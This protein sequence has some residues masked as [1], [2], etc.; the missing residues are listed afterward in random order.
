MLSLGLGLKTTFFGL[1]LESRHVVVLVLA[2]VLNLVV[3]L[4]SLVIILVLFRQ[5]LFFVVFLLSVVS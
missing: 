2:L 3:L 4:T 5:V 1:G